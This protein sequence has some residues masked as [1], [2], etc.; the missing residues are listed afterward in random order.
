MKKKSTFLAPLPC[1]V[2]IYIVRLKLLIL[3]YNCSISASRHNHLKRGLYLVEKLRIFRFIN[4]TVIPIQ[5]LI[6]RLFRY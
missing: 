4:V 2:Y 6:F 3:P 1:P 5:I